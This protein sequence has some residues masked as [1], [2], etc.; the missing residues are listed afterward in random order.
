MAAIQTLIFDLRSVYTA[1]RTAGAVNGGASC[2]GSEARSLP[3]PAPNH[4]PSRYGH[5]MNYKSELQRLKC[6]LQA[7][8]NAY[9]NELD[10]PWSSMDEDLGLAIK[11][12]LK[13]AST[14]GG[15]L[16]LLE[17]CYLPDDPREGATVTLPEWWF[18]IITTFSDLYESSEAEYRTQKVLNEL[19][20]KRLGRGEFATRH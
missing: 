3:N 6:L 13:H 14:S 9:L 8:Y 1:A 15:R 7:D 12:L 19:I 5:P 20:S 11:I 10:K 16:P 2:G 18:E 4:Q 17:T